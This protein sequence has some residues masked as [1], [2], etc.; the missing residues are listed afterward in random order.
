MPHAPSLFRLL[1]RRIYTP[2]IKWDERVTTATMSVIMFIYKKKVLII[3]YIVV[4][5]MWAMLYSAPCPGDFTD[6]NL[7]QRR[8]PNDMLHTT[9]TCMA[10]QLCM[11]NR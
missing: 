6:V 5:Y 2:A 7:G 10:T 11:S 4:L 3:L 9:N 1:F 8:A